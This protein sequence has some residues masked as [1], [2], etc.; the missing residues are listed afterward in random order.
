MSQWSP[1]TLQDPLED[2]EREKQTALKG[3]EAVE[4][5]VAHVVADT[6]A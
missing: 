5:Y 6:A 2:A 1:A 3:I 4:K